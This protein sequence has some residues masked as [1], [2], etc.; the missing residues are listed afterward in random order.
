MRKNPL[1][2]IGTWSIVLVLIWTSYTETKAFVLEETIE[3][4]IK[5]HYKCQF[6][7]PDSA[8]YYLHEALDIAKKDVNKS[9]RLNT[10]L[11]WYYANRQVHLDSSLI[12]IKRATELI[13]EADDSLLI[14]R[15][16]TFS[17]HIYD[18]K[19]NFRK[20]IEWQEQ[21]IAM[22]LILND[23]AAITF[24]YNLLAN[25]Y[26]NLANSS[27]K[28]GHDYRNEE[29]Y[30]DAL[31]YYSQAFSY[32]NNSRCPALVGRNIGIT[33]L[34]M[35]AFSKAEK[36]FEESIQIYQSLQQK[37]GE[38]LTRVK[39]GV[40]YTEREQYQKALEQFF[41]AEQFYKK[42]EKKNSI[43]PLHRNMARVYLRL[44]ELEAAEENAL[45]SLKVSQSRKEN[46]SQ[47]ETIALL[48]E[49]FAQQKDFES[50][51]NYQQ[52]YQSLKDTFSYHEIK[53]ELLNQNLIEEINANKIKL[54]L[55]E[56]DKIITDQKAKNLFLVIVLLII[57][58]ILLF[59]LGSYFYQKRLEKLGLQIKV[60]SDKRA[61]VSQAL[62]E[63]R[64][65]SKQLQTEVEHHIRQLS[66][67]GEGNGAKKN[68]EAIANLYQLRLLTNEDW[69]EFKRLFLNVNPNFF[70]KFIKENPNI[71]VGDLKIA[72]LARLNFNN[73]E[74]GE[75]MAISAESVRKARYRLRQKLQLADNKA[76]QSYI[77][78]L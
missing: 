38:I 19:K 29:L 4:L 2:T 37:K 21:A 73:T 32:C 23:S 67:M 30:K 62:E 17:G 3:A 65:V 49:I 58:S 46:Y 55:A 66:E 52:Q 69:T 72:A 11:A 22:K 75:M 68:K 39:L 12:Y 16:M 13:K 51:H 63:E 71:S 9:L 10:I 57:S 54:Q 27:K 74:T 77:F 48:V 24:S 1:N 45:R 64:K 78:S 36:Y 28:M 15:A 50:A 76:L 44:G 60:E 56:Q 31:S 34:H 6:D 70:D 8:V 53:E 18:R 42:K 5:K 20:A 43:I 41:I 25:S 26:R 47:L 61:E 35:K 40:L 33:Y 7:K 14:A 59:I